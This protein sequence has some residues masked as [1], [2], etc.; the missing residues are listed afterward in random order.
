M[1]VQT[2]NWGSLEVSEEMLIKIPEGLFGFEEYTRFAVIKSQY[3]PFIWLQSCEETALAFL[4][5]DPFLVCRDYEPDIDDSELSKIEIH[6]PSDV[7]LIALVTVPLDGKP[8]TANLLGPIVVN[9]KNRNAIQVVL[10][11]SRWEVK[12]DIVAAIKNQGEKKC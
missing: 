6:E 9:K 5:V 10:N 11:D 3:A 2:K 4:A 7:E 1:L 12:H 8:I